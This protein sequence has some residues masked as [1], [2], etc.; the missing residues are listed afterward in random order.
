MIS[1]AT[2]TIH[3]REMKCVAHLSYLRINGN[4]KVLLLSS[5]DSISQYQFNYDFL[6]VS[7][8]L[9]LKLNDNQYPHIYALN[10]YVFVLVSFFLENKC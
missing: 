5:D 1:Y 3:S 6:L 10:I 9:H 4:Q 8:E 7:N 2:S